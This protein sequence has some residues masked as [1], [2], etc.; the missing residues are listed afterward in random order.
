MWSRLSRSRKMGGCRFSGVSAAQS[1]F[2]SLERHLNNDV[3][4][5]SDSSWPT[6]A[7]PAA[8][9]GTR[10]CRPTAAVRSTLPRRSS[11]DGPT[12]APR[13]AAA[14]SQ[15]AA[16]VHSNTQRG[17]TCQTG[18]EVSVQQNL[19]PDTT[20]PACMEPDSL[21]MEH[22]KA[23][24]TSDTHMQNHISHEQNTWT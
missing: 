2:S 20:A 17:Q 3:T 6:S 15:S 12:R 8:S 24:I 10:C 7:C 1:L 16:S 13:W 14:A 19:P 11:E 21:F 23:S 22:S 4:S 18:T 9:G 5:C